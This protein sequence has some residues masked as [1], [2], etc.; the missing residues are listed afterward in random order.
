MTDSDALVSL[1]EF[2]PE[3]KQAMEYYS[4]CT[5]INPDTGR[6]WTEAQI[7]DRMGISRTT[8]WARR[9]EWAARG[10]KNIAL[11]RL[12]E[13]RAQFP[14]YHEAMLRAMVNFPDILQGMVD[15]ANGGA[16]PK[17]RIAAA[18]FLYQVLSNYRD[19]VLSVIKT[20]E[21]EERAAEE[22]M[23]EA[24][25][26]KDDVTTEGDIA[27]QQFLSKQHTFSPGTPPALTRNIVLELRT[28]GDGDTPTI[29]IVDG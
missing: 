5:A 26:K 27:A 13:I 7:A 23:R 14:E 19:E 9:Q 2:D 28:D 10:Q 1:E 24:A 8:L 21:E 17:D 16:L 29:K 3:V 15:I 12:S 20:R 25:E 4:L 22:A 11:Q 6:V 18:R